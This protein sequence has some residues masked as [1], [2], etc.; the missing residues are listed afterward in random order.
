MVV[1]GDLTNT[2]TSARYYLGKD[3]TGSFIHAASA[4]TTQLSSYSGSATVSAT[5][6]GGGSSNDPI[7]AAMGFDGGPARSIVGNG[8]T[9]GTD[10]NRSGTRTTI[11]LGRNA[12]NTAGTYG[13]GLYDF[14]GIAPEKL[15]NAALQALAVPA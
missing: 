2:G 1:R 6:G 5:I 9:V 13:D 15:S 10:A 7:G 12:T 3:T 14:V 8:G 11:Y 4:S